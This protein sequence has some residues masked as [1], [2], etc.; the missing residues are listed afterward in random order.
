MKNNVIIISP[1]IPQHLR[2]VATLP[3]EMSRAPKQHN[4]LDSS[5][6]CL[7]ATCQARWTWCSHCRYVSVFLAVC[8]SSTD[9]LSTSTI[10]DNQ[11]AEA[12][13]D[14]WVGQTV[15][16]FNWSRHWSD[17]STAWVRRP[18]ARRTHWTFDVKTAGCDR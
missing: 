16:A 3:C 8:V 12:G 2:S 13:N 7:G 14:H 10:H 6:G 1:K 11:P 18:A 4:P 15:A 5:L 17:A 9:C